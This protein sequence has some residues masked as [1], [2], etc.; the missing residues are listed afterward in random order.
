MF[1]MKCGQELPDDALFCM[2][3]GTNLQDFINKTSS[4]SSE[5]IK[6]STSAAVRVV[7]A[8]CTN[9]GGS[10]TLDPNTE[11][12][13]CPFCETTFVVSQAIQN[14][15]IKIQAG[16]VHIANANVQTG[17]SV[18]NLLLRAN[19]YLKEGDMATAKKYY[20]QVLDLD[21]SNADA[22]TGKEKCTID[23]PLSQAYEYFKK[24]DYDTAKSYFNRALDIDPS[25]TDARVGAG[26]CNIGIP[27]SRANE[28][29]KKKDYATAKIY[30]SRALEMDASN[31]D[32]KAGVEI[33]NY[34]IHGNRFE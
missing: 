15:N 34:W 8:K 27:L 22:R 30:F 19:E 25:N 11:T 31:A 18:D 12:A 4:S 14:Y 32:A 6:M 1:C 21:A 20:D 9:C 16:T 17:P 2:K 10:L 3:C 26:K 7:P 33:C 13:I 5:G 23:V 29:L 28:Y 24:G